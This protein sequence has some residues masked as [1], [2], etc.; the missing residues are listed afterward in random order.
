MNWLRTLGT[1][2]FSEYSKRFTISASGNIYLLAEISSI[3][4]SYGNNDIFVM[5]LSS[6]TGSVNFLKDLGSSIDD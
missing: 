6:S 2:G 1:P 3:D 4:V 5:G